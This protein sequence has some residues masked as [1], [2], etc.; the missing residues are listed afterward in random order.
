MR[1]GAFI[2]ALIAIVGSGVG[3]WFIADRGTE[4]VEDR[5]HAELTEALEAAGETWAS[6]EVDGLNV[7]VRGEAENEATRFGALELVRQIVDPRRIVDLTTIENPDP[8]APPSFALELL[9]NE[10]EISLIGLVPTISDR[11]KA[12]SSEIHDT[13]AEDGLAGN[14]S[15]ML[16][17]ADHPAPDAWA[18]SMGFGLEILTELP[19]AKISVTPG[20]VQVTAV[21]DSP[22]ARQS[23][24]TALLDRAPENVELVLNL[25]SPRPVIAPFRVSYRY[26]G[27]TG[28]F[29]SCNAESLEDAATIEAAA[30]ETGLEGEAECAIGI[31]APN[32]HWAEAVVE[33]LSALRAL[34]GG[35]FSITDTDALLSGPEG[36][37][38]ET[39]TRTGETLA[40]ALPAGVILK[41]IAPP[42]MEANADGV[43]VYSPQFD[44]VLLQEGQ[45]RIAGAVRDETSRAAIHSYAAA[46]FGHDM[47]TDA[48]VLDP[49]LPEGWPVRVLAGLDAL[50]GTTE[51]ILKVTN[52]DL[53]IEGW[54]MS[55]DAD[56]DVE[57]M[58]RDRVQ[59]STVNIRYNA[60]AAAAE[61]LAEARAAGRSPE[62]CV[63]Q[64]AAILEN[65]S[66]GFRPGS[67]EITP[68]SSG[69]IAAIADVLRECPGAEFE[70]AGHTDNQGSQEGNLRLSEQRALAVRFALEDQDLPLIAFRARG[71]GAAFPIA[72]NSTEEGRSQNRRIELSLY[73]GETPTPDEEPRILDPEICAT[74]VTSILADATIQFNAGSSSITPDSMPV[75]ESI[76]G[77]LRS[78]PGL[79]FEI[80]GHTDSQ[81]SE[82]VNQRISQERAEAVVSALRSQGVEDVELTA[83]GYG[84]E[85]P[86]ADNGT[87]EGRS[88]NRRIEFKMLETEPPEPDEDAEGAE[89][90]EQAAGGAGCEAAVTE[91]LELDTFVFQL[92]SSRVSPESQ[93][94]LDALGAE[95]AKCPEG[96][97]FEIA[98]YTDNR[99]SAEGNLRLSQARAESVLSELQEL[100]PEVVLTAR[101]YGEE[102]PV[103]DNDTPEGRAQNRRIEIRR[104]GGPEPEEEAAEA[105]DEPVAAEDDSAS[106]EEDAVEADNG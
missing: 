106:G 85:N 79:A 52:N 47:V 19:R 62:S 82:T 46:L 8:V 58:L 45:V 81:G 10:A 66:I 27:T 39:L 99:G 43:Q 102:D 37:D 15:D 55:E 35:T 101:G 9:R 74:E 72:D 32:E 48:T 38:A 59:K 98:G 93:V 1:S 6:I 67:A 50:K 29:T 56:A 97:E 40:A 83:Q 92:G 23:L 88:L 30:Q 104:T 12:T 78:C 41:T 68:Q 26:D 34:G 100:V 86:I 5:T 31:G 63:S 16:E 28:R 14:I 71:Y 42:N 73:T 17:M 89:E 76:S 60:E 69:I 49:E 54:G 91:L 61:A 80:G 22:E 51:G 3:S 87:R 103:A 70:V 77:I 53:V 21:A 96:T 84:E 94:F 20:E 64:I 44:A 65:D 18:A 11:D 75:L 24:E 2:F 90:T 105:S 36:V 13:L 25:S 95:M 33:G 7:T 57:E 4:I